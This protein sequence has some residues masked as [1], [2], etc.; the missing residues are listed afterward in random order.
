ML[1]LFPSLL[2]A[3]H[4][5]A[6][7]RTREDGRFF[8]LLFRTF[9]M[10]LSL[11]AGFFIAGTHAFQMFLKGF[12][13]ISEIKNPIKIALHLPYYV[14]SVCKKNHFLLHPPL[15]FLGFWSFFTPIG[16]EGNLLSSR[17]PKGESPLSIHVPLGS[18]GL[19]QMAHNRFQHGQA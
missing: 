6:P 17:K 1:W 15:L 3:L 14:L 7:G 18:T 12:A 19:A 11:F 4:P 10:S 2:L 8:T 16:R 5:Q 9:K 13:Q